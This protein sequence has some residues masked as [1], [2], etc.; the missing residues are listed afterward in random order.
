MKFARFFKRR[1]KG[2]VSENKSLFSIGVFKGKSP[3][4]LS[5][6]GKGLNPVLTREDVSDAKALLVADPFMLRVENTW[7]MFFEVLNRSTGKGEIGLAK[8]GNAFEWHYQKIVLAEPFHLSYPYV[9]QWEDEFYM[10]PET[11][12]TYSIQLFR[13]KNFPFGW[14]LAGTL[15]S[16]QRFADS[17]IIYHNEKWWLFT[18]TNPDLKHDTLRVFYAESLYGIWKEHPSSPVIQGN[19]HIARPAGRVF[20]YDGRLVRYA[21]DCYP[22]YGTQVSAFFVELTEDVYSEKEVPDNPVLSPSGSG[23]NAHGMHHVDP[24]LVKDGEWVACVDGW[25]GVDSLVYNRDSHD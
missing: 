16:N 1:K 7:Y 15:L 21:Q 4:G 12:R 9:F 13:A 10:I 23:W 2:P 8:S 17:S 3:F 20:S 19:P 6:S 18:E 25:I 22:T 14:A 5:P 24:H 11:A